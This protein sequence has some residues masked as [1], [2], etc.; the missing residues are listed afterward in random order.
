MLLGVDLKKNPAVIEAAYN[1]KKGVTAAFNRNLLV[2]INR[3]LDGNF[4][5]RPLLAPR[6]LSSARGADRDAPRQFVRAARPSRR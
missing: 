2:R 1:D 4:S 6:L 3:E 5:V